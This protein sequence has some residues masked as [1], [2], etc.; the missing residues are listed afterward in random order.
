MQDVL[1]SFL[2]FAMKFSLN[3]DILKYYRFADIWS[4]IFFWG[5]IS[6]TLIMQIDHISNDKILLYI[7]SYVN[8]VSVSITIYFNGHNRYNSLLRK[9][10]TIFI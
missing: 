5:L 9:Y 10:K 7:F 1:T 4:K 2:T 8:L 6:F 3:T